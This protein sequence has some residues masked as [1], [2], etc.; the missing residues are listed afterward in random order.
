MK[1]NPLTKLA[2]RIQARRLVTRYESAIA[3][4]TA[5]KPL[6]DEEESRL[7]KLRTQ[8]FAA[9]ESAQEQEG[10]VSLRQAVESIFRELPVGAEE[11]RF[12]DFILSSEIEQEC[13]GSAAQLSSHWYDYD[14]E[15]DG[16]DALF[17][18]GSGVIPE[19]LAQGI[20]VEL[21]QVVREIQWDDFPIRIVTQDSE[22]EAARVVVTLP[23]GVL[24]AGKVTF[25]PAL[26]RSK[27]GAIAKL[28][29][30]VLS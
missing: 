23:L 18:R 2:D 3:Y 15:F 13:S 12:A 5:G 1:G 25:T 6:S 19:F 26:P 16:D 8:L 21:G 11:R 27:Q 30:G 10:D 7:D 24:Q 14:D 9:I 20:E 22:F 17:P 4:N 29:M 28:G